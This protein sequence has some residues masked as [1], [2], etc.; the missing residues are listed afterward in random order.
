[1]SLSI[2]AVT[3]W[4]VLPSSPSSPS[5]A[6]TAWNAASAG[7]GDRRVRHMMS[8]GRSGGPWALRGQASPL[9]HAVRHPAEMRG[10]RSS[11][12]FSARW[13][14]TVQRDPRRV[15]PWKLMLTS[16]TC[17][18]M[19]CMT[20]VALLTILV[21]QGN[22]FPAAAPL[23][24]S[25]AMKP[26]SSRSRI[27]E[28]RSC[29]FSAH[30][31]GASGGIAGGSAGGCSEDG[32]SPVMV[33]LAVA[34][35][36]APLPAGRVWGAGP[37]TTVGDSRLRGSVVASVPGVEGTERRCRARCASRPR[38]HAGEGSPRRGHGGSHHSWHVQVVLV[39][40]Q[41]A[42]EE[43]R[44][45]CQPRVAC[46]R[47]PLRHAGVAKKAPISLEDGSRAVPLLFRE[48]GELVQVAE[49]FQ[50]PSVV[51]V[52]HV[53]RICARCALL[54]RPKPAPL[55]QVAEN[56][57]NRRPIQ[58]RCVTGTASNATYIM[59]D[60]DGP[61][62]GLQFRSW[63]VKCVPAPDRSLHDRRAWTTCLR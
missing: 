44:S 24:T 38:V 35:R 11:F 51:A 6:W 22:L 53:L 20:D 28:T 12:S 42:A 47:L 15:W 48:S 60:P 41:V 61:R 14:S 43:E 57:P 27:Q 16:A 50:R 3:A 29:C 26:W 23:A 8:R 52:V 10:P 40:E 4:A 2:S 32:C 54:S 46:S 34:C 62:L 49:D 25:C 45:D 21:G 7:S 58:H 30:S 13:L 9:M 36:T 31:S 55:E 19:S 56:G 33:L 63:A 18:P 39:A 17:L 1:M 59:C 5:S 37:V